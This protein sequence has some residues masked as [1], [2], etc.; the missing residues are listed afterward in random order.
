MK[1]AWKRLSYSQ[2]KHVESLVDVL[3]TIFV[4]IP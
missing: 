1:K 3:L 4:F 2:K